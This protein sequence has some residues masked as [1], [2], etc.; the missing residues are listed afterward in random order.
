MTNRA[1]DIV[2]RC[3]LSATPHRRTRAA[4]K[5]IRMP[6]TDARTHYEATLD[7]GF[8]QRFN[9][10]CERFYKRLDFVF[11]AIGL[12]GGFA[13]ASSLLGTCSQQTAVAAGLLLAA[14]SII[15]RLVAPGAKAE[16]H[17]QMKRQ[18]GQLRSQ[19][20]SLS[21]EALDQQLRTLQTDGPLGISGLS[22]V[23]YNANV[24][25]EGREDFAMPLTR[26]NKMLALFA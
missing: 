21:L 7:I 20:P 6:R 5:E 10:L 25:S 22:A 14:N 12:I 26:W 1:T 11:G 2:G 17:A 23:A 3:R 9:E 19:A 15:E 8:G 4:L 13:A 18:Y 24:R 16:I